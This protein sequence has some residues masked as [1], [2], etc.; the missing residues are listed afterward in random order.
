ME[1]DF[2][3]QRGDAVIA[4]EVKARGRLDPAA[5]AGLKAVAELSGV[6]RRIL[7]YLGGHRFRHETGV[8]V[9]PFASFLEELEKG[10]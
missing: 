5:F 4:I 1:V 9:L 7:I 10:L 6:S 3:L 2:L 8:E